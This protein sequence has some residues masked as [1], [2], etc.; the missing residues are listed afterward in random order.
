MKSFR[1]N[2]PKSEDDLKTITEDITREEE[3]HEHH[4]HHHEEDIVIVLNYLVEVM[5]G[6]KEMINRLESRVKSI[7]RQNIILGKLQGLLLNTYLFPE[8]YDKEKIIEE[9]RNLLKELEKD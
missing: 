6:F 5:N 1:I 9:L 2:I 8:K 7:E 4:H 3:M